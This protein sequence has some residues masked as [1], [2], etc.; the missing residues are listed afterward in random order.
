MSDASKNG[1]DG[2][3]FSTGKIHSKRWKTPSLT[4]YYDKDIPDVANKILKD[5]GGKLEYKTIFTDKDFLQKFKNDDLDYDEFFPDDYDLNS[6]LDELDDI[7]AGIEGGYIKETP[8]IYLTNPVNEY[9]ESGVSLYSPI[10]AT[11]IAGTVASQILGPEDDI[12][13]NEG[14]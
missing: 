8:T 11:G 6:M 2:V 14:I 10:V 4:K 9:I 3:A 1:Y 12:V 13:K 5:T 7:D